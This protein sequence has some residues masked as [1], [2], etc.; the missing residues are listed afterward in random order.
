LSG[1]S[2]SDAWQARFAMA[3]ALRHLERSAEA[4]ALLDE[5]EPQLALNPAFEGVFQQLRRQLVS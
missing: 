1:L 3:E 2:G 4:R 5:L